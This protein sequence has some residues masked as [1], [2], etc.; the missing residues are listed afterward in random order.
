M[1]KIPELGTIEMFRSDPR[2]FGKGKIQPLTYNLYGNSAVPKVD[3]VSS[4]TESASIQR[5]AGSQ[6]SFQSFLMDALNSMNSQQNEVSK[7]SEK[8][9]TSPDEVDVHDVTIAMAKA[10]MSLNLAQNVIDRMVSSW[11]DI[12]T[13]R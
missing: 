9:I 4:R 13:T 7:L 11:N 8:L 5:T 3:G 6:K 2:H 10:R 12:T 1:M